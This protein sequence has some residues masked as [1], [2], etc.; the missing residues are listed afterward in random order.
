MVHRIDRIEDTRKRKS[1]FMMNMS[2]V[3]LSVL[4]SVTMM[5]TMV[6]GL[7]F[8]GV[9]GRANN[10]GDDDDDGGG[11]E[12]EVLVGGGDGGDN[13]G[14]T[15]LGYHHTLVSILMMRW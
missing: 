15:C 7:N 11:G 2:L 14:V 12:E 5:M 10:D 9:V 3:I 1:Y 8:K 13:L 6:V 4:M